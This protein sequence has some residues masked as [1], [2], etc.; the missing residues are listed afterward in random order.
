MRIEDLHIAD[1]TR[2]ACLTRPLLP[3]LERATALTADER[4]ERDWDPRSRR[5]A[6]WKVR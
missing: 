2:Y 4:W 3:K 1:Q 5:A 6:G